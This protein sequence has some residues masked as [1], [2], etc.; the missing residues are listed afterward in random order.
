MW[1]RETGK[2]HNYSLPSVLGAERLKVLSGLRFLKDASGVISPETE[3]S[4][5]YT[6]TYYESICLL[7][8]GY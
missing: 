6:G 8:N 1:I 3:K 7:K 5:T 4:I 2:R